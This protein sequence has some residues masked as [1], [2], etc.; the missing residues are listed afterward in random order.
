LRSCQF[1]LPLFS[2]LSACHLL[3]SSSWHN[4][5]GDKQRCAPIYEK[6]GIFSCLMLELEVSCL[7]GVDELLKNP[8]IGKL[9]VQRMPSSGA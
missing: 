4:P 2:S 1:V 5:H 7:T 9:F 8:T 6:G 3:S